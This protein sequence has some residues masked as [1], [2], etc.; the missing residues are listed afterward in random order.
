MS[1]GRSRANPEKNYGTNGG[2]HGRK[3]MFSLTFDALSGAFGD[4]NEYLMQGR[5]IDDLFP[6]ACQLQ[7]LWNGGPPDFSFHDV[8][9]NPDVDQDLKRLEIYL[10]AYF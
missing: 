8:V 6:Y 10:D 1:T 2:L 4:P 9:V 5:S 7:I 3:Y